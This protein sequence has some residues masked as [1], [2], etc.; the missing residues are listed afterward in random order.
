MQVKVIERAQQIK[1]QAEE[2]IRKE[3]ELEANVRKPA[4]AQKFKE[5]KIAE[6]NKNKIILE[7]EA[8]A[9]TIRVCVILITC[10]FSL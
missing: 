7:A 3:K 2:I 4:E 6:A 8:E 10:C 9:E 1:V 5:E